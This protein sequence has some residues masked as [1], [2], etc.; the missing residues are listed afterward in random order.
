MP[1]T[2]V[3][4]DDDRA[5][6]AGAAPPPAAATTTRRRRKDDNNGCARAVGSK[7]LDASTEEG[8]AGERGAEICR[9]SGRRPPRGA[10]P[11]K[12]P[13]GQGACRPGCPAASRHAVRPAPHIRPG[14]SPSYLL[15]LHRRRGGVESFASTERMAASTPPPDDFAA[16]PQGQLEARQLGTPAALTARQQR[17]SGRASRPARCVPNSAWIPCGR[18]GPASWGAGGWGLQLPGGNPQIS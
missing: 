7:S 5:R 11:P 15:L 8:V 1:T 9:G 14:T 6:G 10:P 3:D 4:R 18:V 13:S 12:P 16:R 17:P 2:I